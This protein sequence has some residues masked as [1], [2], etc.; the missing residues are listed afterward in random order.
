MA[1]T[2]QSRR[3]SAADLDALIPEPRRQGTTEL[4]LVGPDYF[5][6]SRAD[7]WP[8]FLRD[9]PTF[10][11]LTQPVKALGQRLGVLTRLT[12]LDLGQG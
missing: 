6:A 3:L 10:Y 1:S 4:V 7:Q 5:W 2:P 8:E 9:R 12:S 11:L